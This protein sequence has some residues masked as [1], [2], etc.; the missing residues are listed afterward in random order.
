MFMTEDGAKEC[1]ECAAAADR[2]TCKECGTQMLF[3]VEDRRCGLCNPDWA[4]VAA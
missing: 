2:L 4:P 3:E 1:P